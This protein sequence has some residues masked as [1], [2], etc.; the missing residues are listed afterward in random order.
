VLSDFFARFK[1]PRFLQNYISQKTELTR[2]KSLT[3]QAFLMAIYP[4]RGGRCP[5]ELP[6][7]LSGIMLSFIVFRQ[8]E[9]AWAMPKRF[10]QR[11]L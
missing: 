7:P 10:I 1:T 3:C 2:Q 11:F 6:H 5:L 4:I 9:S 8:T